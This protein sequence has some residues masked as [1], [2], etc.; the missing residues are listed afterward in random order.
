VS[1]RARQGEALHKKKE[2]N[3]NTNSNKQQPTQTCLNRIT[4]LYSS[5][6][7]GAWAN[8]IDG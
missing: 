2:G 1:E 5:G 6:L 7:N 4:E 3:F 8:F